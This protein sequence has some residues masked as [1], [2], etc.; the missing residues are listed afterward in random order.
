MLALGSLAAVNLPVIVA[1][2]V[3]AEHLRVGPDLVSLQ[4]H[5]PAFGAVQWAPMKTGSRGRRLS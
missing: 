1:V 3:A 2:T 5:S 4:S